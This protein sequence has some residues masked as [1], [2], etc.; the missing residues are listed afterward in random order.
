M[1]LRKKKKIIVNLVRLHIPELK[2]QL[3][4]SNRKVTSVCLSICVFKN[5]RLFIWK[6]IELC[7]HQGI[8]SMSIYE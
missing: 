8:I 2:V 1:F 5:C 4:I 7:L 3:G 6:K